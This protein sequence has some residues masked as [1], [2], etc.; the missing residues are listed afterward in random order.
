MSDAEIAIFIMAL[1]FTSNLWNSKRHWRWPFACRWPFQRSN[2]S[3][4]SFAGEVH[5]NFSPMGK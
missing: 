5:F 2:R 4:C 3:R 1:R